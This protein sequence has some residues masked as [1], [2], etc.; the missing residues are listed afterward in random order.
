ML[1]DI[2]NDWVAEETL[3]TELNVPRELLRSMRPTLAEVDVMLFG[4]VL[5]VKKDAATTIALTL[6]L[7]WPSTGVTTEK[8]AQSQIEELTVASAPRGDGWHFPNKRMIQAR[9]ANA[10]LVDVLVMDSRKYVTL[11]RTGQPMTFRAAK[12]TN[13][14]HWVLVG[15]EP[16]FRG[17][18]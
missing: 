4:N 13:G 10:E 18:W 9:R 14:P 5:A 16:R 12:S 17:Q 6:G 1:P 2:P 15:R 7:I 11:L 3:A 8:T